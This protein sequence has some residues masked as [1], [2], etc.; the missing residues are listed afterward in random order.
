MCVGFIVF[1]TSYLKMI[2]A[3]GVHFLYSSPVSIL[4]MGL[5]C[6]WLCA[7][8]LLWW[9][10]YQNAPYYAHMFWLIFNGAFA[11]MGFVCLVS[12]ASSQSEG[13][14]AAAALLWISAGLVGMLTSA[15]WIKGTRQLKTSCP[16]ADTPRRGCGQCCVGCL[17]SWRAWVLGFGVLVHVFFCALTLGV[18]IQAATAAHDYAAYPP[19]GNI[20]TVLVRG[21]ALRMHLH[22]T[23]AR[24]GGSATFVFAHGG[25]A[26]CLSMQALAGALS[27]SR[28]ACIYDG[29]GYGFTPSAYPRANQTAWA[30]SGEVL[31]ALLAAA[32][33]PGPFVCVGHSAGAGTCLRFAVAAAAAA[34]GG[35]GAVVGVVGLDGYP[36]LIR[37]GAFRPGRSDA[38]GP[39]LGATLLFAVLAGPT[40]FTRNLVGGAEASF[41]P[42]DRGAAR[43]ALYA[44]SRFWPCQYWGERA[45]APRGGSR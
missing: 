17:C 24:G 18:T 14:S 15:H 22:C 20:H 36:D 40:G 30:S 13:E 28:R 23:G 41:V 32:A 12:F 16:T 42:A 37:A 6:F 38:A 34:A 27:P 1:M 2:S 3:D 7:V 25:G 26:N 39:M 31:A 10:V 8:E 35:A 11:A 43:A 9:L 19:P 45:R 5:G 33:E 29:L 21:V 4:W 44:Q